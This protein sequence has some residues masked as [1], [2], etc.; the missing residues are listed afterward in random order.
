MEQVV[1]TVNAI[2]VAEIEIRRKLLVRLL[3]E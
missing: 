3:V 1:Y 2:P